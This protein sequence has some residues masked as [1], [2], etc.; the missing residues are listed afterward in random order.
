MKYGVKIAVPHYLAIG[1]SKAEFM[2]S[3]PADMAAYDK[4]H[5][6]R[7]EEQNMMQRHNGLYIADA[8]MS[9]IGNSQWFKGKGVP[10][11]EY[12][13]EP[14]AIFTNN[15]ANITEEEKQREVDKFFAQESARRVNWRRT[16]KK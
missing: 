5:R 15:T 3:C 2:K 14:Y 8:I 12:P 10:V 13:K 6:L 9:T 16:H 1:V 11:N 7:L 4:A